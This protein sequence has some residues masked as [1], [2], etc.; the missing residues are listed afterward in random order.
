MSKK[1]VFRTIIACGFIFYFTGCALPNLSRFSVEESDIKE[2]FR[3][4]FLVTLNWSHEDIST[5]DTFN[6]YYKAQGEST[7]ILLDTVP[8]AL[9][10]LEISNTDVGD[11]SWVFGVSAV[12]ALGNE[13][14]IHSSLEATADPNTG[15]YLLWVD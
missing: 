4:A 7:W 3:S 10:L 15:W 1:R 6:V 2:I 13:S 5:V 12:D 14:E 9:P 11:G 8:A